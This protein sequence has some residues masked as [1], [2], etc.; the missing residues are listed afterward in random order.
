MLHPIM[1]AIVTINTFI[2][3]TYWIYILTQAF[4]KKTEDEENPS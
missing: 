4:F 1:I 3:I 2:T